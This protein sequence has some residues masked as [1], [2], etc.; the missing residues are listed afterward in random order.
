VGEIVDR[1]IGMAANCLEDI[2]PAFSADDLERLAVLVIDFGRV[3]DKAEDVA[4]R[5]FHAFPFKHIFP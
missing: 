3:N 5:M 1:A 2:F 4:I